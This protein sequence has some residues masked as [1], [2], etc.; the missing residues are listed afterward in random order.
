MMTRSPRSVC[1]CPGTWI[2]SGSIPG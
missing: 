1:I 2:W